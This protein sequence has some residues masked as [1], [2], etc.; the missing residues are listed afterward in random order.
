MDMT[1]IGKIDEYMQNELTEKRILHTE[2]V[3]ETACELARQY[4]ADEDK[5]LLAAKCHDICRKWDDARMNAFVTLNN[6]GDRYLDNINLSHSKAAELVA[7]VAFGIEDEDILNAISYH[8][9][10]RAGM[11]LLEKIIFIADAIEPQREYPGVE[12]LR[13]AAR[14]DLDKACLLSLQGTREYVLSQ[15][16]PFDEDS[17]EAI[18]WFELGAP[19][20]GYPK[21]K[22]ADPEDEFADLE[23]LGVDL[24]EL[25]LF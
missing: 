7:R 20:E 22:A 12:S 8:T 16:K 10:G 23:S 1:C 11:S 4:G 13:A 2:G 24:S 5:A 17:A 9:T 3:A 15:E 14:E 21:K 19:A 18:A 6:L 25:M